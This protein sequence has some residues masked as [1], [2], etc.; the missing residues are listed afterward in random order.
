ML[1]SNKLIY[2]D[3][4]KC[5]SREVAEKCLVLP[6]RANWDEQ[7]A[8]CPQQDCWL[9]KLLDEK[10]VLTYSSRS[11]STAKCVFL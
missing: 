11:E 4:L 2:G 6:E 5:G 3:R 1:L 7:H 10:F 9:D 8:G